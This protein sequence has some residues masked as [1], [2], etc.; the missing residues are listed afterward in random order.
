M[1]VRN[2]PAIKIKNALIIADLHIGVTRELYDSGITIPSQARTLSKRINELKKLTKTTRLIINGDLKHKVPGIAWQERKE[3]PAFLS[4]LKFRNIVI[5]KGNHDGWI[6]RMLSNKLKKKIKIKKSF[7]IDDYLIT[8]GNR[9]VKTNK[10][11]I[12]IGHNHPYVKFIDDLGS[13]YYEPVWLKGTIKILRKGKE[14]IIMP[15][16]NEL[17]GMNIVNNKSDNY[18]SWLAGP[19]AKL[20]EKSKTHAYLLDGTDLGKV[21]DLIVKS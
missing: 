19:I 4:S 5:I 14:I 13:V 11:C 9:R 18:I 12:I 16:F 15:A 20:L 3:I 1:F 21:S 6:E 17:S 2:K 7:G 10:K 8:H